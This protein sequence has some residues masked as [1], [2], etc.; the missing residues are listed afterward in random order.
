MLETE[1][2]Q[3]RGI[4]SPQFMFEAVKEKDGAKQIKVW[5]EQNSQRF[6]LPTLFST[7]EDGRERLAKRVLNYL[8]P[9]DQ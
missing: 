8:L 3:K 2:C 7:Y 9:T 4:A 5:A 6:E 1:Y